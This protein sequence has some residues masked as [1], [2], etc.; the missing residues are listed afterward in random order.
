M[1]ALTSPVVVG[2]GITLRYGARL[3]LATS[4]FTVPQAGLT[5]LIGP[6]GSGKSTLLAAIAGLT[7]PDEGELAVM[8]TSPTEAR[9]R[10]S[11]VLQ[12]TKVNE[13]LP[14]TVSEVVAMGRYASLGLLKRFQRPDRAVVGEALER[15]DLTRLAGRHLSELSGGERQR[16]FVAQ[17][18]VQE[19]DLL[20]MDEP[21][22][23]LDLI[24]QAAIEKVIVEE[25]SRG[26]TVIV[27]THDLADA[28][29]ADHVLLLAGRVVAAGPPEEV[30]VPEKLAEAYRAHVLD[31]DGRLLL[32]DAA[33]RPADS[34]HIH[35]D[36]GAA[37]H[38]HD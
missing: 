25:R 10:V 29:K 16:V 11:L 14:V 12:S 37:T 18:L 2:R 31:A 5:V 17:G 23:G 20:L 8:G 6:N 21:L 26:K 32:D 36:L 19:H 7:D 3:A 4:D 33:H 28:S 13:V 27:T 35:V 15:L 38:R 9:S 30:L 22:T 34:R 24:S 1:P